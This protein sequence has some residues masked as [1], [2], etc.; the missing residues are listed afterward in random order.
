MNPLRF[1]LPGLLFVRISARKVAQPSNLEFSRSVVEQFIE[2]MRFSLF[3]LLGIAG[4][5]H[6]LKNFLTYSR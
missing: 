6:Y 3:L 2:S 1:K 4:Y 5:N